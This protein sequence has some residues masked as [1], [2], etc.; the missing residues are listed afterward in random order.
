[1]PPS[2]VELIAKQVKASKAA[3]SATEGLG[4]QPTT[5]RRK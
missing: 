5:P 3:V 2:T 4:L 1:V